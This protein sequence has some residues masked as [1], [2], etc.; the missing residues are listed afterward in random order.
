MKKNLLRLS[1]FFLIA[2][3]F[4][5]AACGR[6]EKTENNVSVNKEAYSEQQ[7]LMGTYVRIQIFDDGKK[8][9]LSQAFDKVKELADKITVNEPDAENSEVAEINRQAGVEPV[10]VSSDVFNL[11]KTAYA[12]SEIPE[13]GFDL[14][15]GPIT[16]LWHIGF[17]D[18]RKPEQS[19]IDE[20]LKLVNH[21]DVI[22]DEKEKTV[23]LKEK[24]MALDLGAIAKGFITDEVVE[25][26][27][28]NHVTTAIIDLG[29]NIYVMGQSPK[30]ENGFWTVG[31]Q[32]PEKE[33]NQVVGSLPATDQSLVTSGI[34]ERN[35]E[36]DGKLYHHLFDAKTGYPFENELAGVSIISEKSIDGD[37]LSTVVF[38]MGVA[39]GMAFVEDLDQTEA[40]FVTKDDEIYVS[41]GLK[42]SFKLN[43]E[44]RYT[45]KEI[46]NR[47]N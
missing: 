20:A 43:E 35:L 12:Y 17:D 2:G 41:S 24:N 10:K 6:T 8:E 46:E 38:S 3:V 27:K 34:Y 7:Y 33:R 1:F 21:E 15:V 36:V 19:E 31:I 32:D 37:G 26:L 44:A 22:L 30:K 14:S 4:L 40:V 16:E 5:F 9:V 29:G 47:N 23:F 25:V 28:K 11:I 42:E 18:A 39:K 13:Q 45:L